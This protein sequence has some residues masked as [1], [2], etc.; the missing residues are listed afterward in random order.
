ME[1]GVILQQGT[2][3]QE[4]P[5]EIIDEINKKHKGEVITAELVRKIEKELTQKI[6]I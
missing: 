1:K 4:I 6:L 3:L 5:I 2:P